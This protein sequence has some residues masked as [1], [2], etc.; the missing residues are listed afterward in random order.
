MIKDQGG[1]TTNL[2]TAIDDTIAGADNGTTYVR[3]NTSKSGSYLIHLTDTPTGFSQMKTLTIDVRARTTGA[4]D[5]QTTLLA[6]IFQ[7][8]GV[9]PLTGE[10]AVATNPGASSFKTISGVSFT[11][12]TGGSKAIWDGAQLAYAGRTCPSE[13]RKQRSSG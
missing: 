8:D 7:A 6:Q 12:L 13:R 9:T 11:G 2:Y 1:G 4:V 5:D 3:N 10:I